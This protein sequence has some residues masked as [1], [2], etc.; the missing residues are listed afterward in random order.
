MDSLSRQQKLILESILNKK[1]QISFVHGKA[2]TG[3]S[4]LLRALKEQL[5]VRDVNYVVVGPTGMSIAG[6]EGAETLSS[7]LGATTDS[8]GIPSALIAKAKAH[9]YDM[10]S[11][12]IM[13]ECGMVSPADFTTLER[14][15]RTAKCN[16]SMF[17]GTPIVMIGDVFQ[18]APIDN[19]FFNTQTWKAIEKLDCLS[20]FQLEENFRRNELDDREDFDDL[21][22]LLSTLRDGSFAFNVRAQ[23]MIDYRLAQKRPPADMEQLLEMVV[24][25][26]TNEIA[27]VFNNERL[28][29]LDGVEITFETK[30][31]TNVLKVKVDARI[32]I[33]QNI[34]DGKNTL[35]ISN[36]VMGIAREFVDDKG[37]QIVGGTHTLS[38]AH[39]YCCRFERESDGEIIDIPCMHL[40]TSDPEQKKGPVAF[41]FRLGYAVTIHRLQGQTIERGIINGAKLFGGRSHVYTAFSRFKSLNDGFYLMDVDSYVLKHA[42][43]KVK[44]P[45]SLI[46]FINRHG[47]K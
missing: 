42:I 39:Q 28:D 30:N 45:A 38:K 40:H 5:D 10:I 19:F 26:S 46:S 47:L 41:P 21:E 4:F 33:S 9:R 34:Y 15:M 8:I 16:K 3:K 22:F 18:L 12:I 37:N 2:G 17:G 7:F 13:D 43:A 11:M 6:V 23:G 44:E 35:L 25:C 36:G 20:V 24:L 31:K 27:N 14:V 32:Q 1:N 29:M